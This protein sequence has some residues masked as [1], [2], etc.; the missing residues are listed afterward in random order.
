MPIS[1]RL[2]A[3]LFAAVRADET[4][5]ITQDLQKTSKT[6][7]DQKPLNSLLEAA[8]GMLKNGE[9]P[10]AIDFADRVL[11]DINATIIDAIVDESRTAQAALFNHWHRF[12]HLIRFELLGRADDVYNHKQVCKD[13]QDHHVLCREQQHAEC[14][15][16]AP[17][18]GDDHRKF[19][20]DPHD[21]S[22]KR[23]CERELYERH[24]EWVDKE[25]MLREAHEEL[26]GHFCPPDANGTLHTFRVEAAPMMTQYIERKEEAE[27][28]ELEYDNLRPSCI[29]V[30]DRLDHTTETC[31][32][33]QRDMEHCACALDRQIG[34]TITWFMD[35]Y[36]RLIDGW[37]RLVTTTKADE[38]IRH[39]EYVTLKNVECLLARIH[40]L[41]GRPCD[42]EGQVDEE[43]AHC[44]EYA[45]T[46]GVCTFMEISVA[47]T[48][49]VHT[50]PAFPNDPWGTCA[51][52]P[53]SDYWKYTTLMDSFNPVHPHD[54]A[55]A[56]YDY[57]LQH[58]E[59]QKDAHGELCLLYPEPPAPPPPCDW[60]PWVSECYCIPRPE[61]KPCDYEWMASHYAILPD[62][63]QAPFAASN[64][65]CNQYPECTT[66]EHHD[67]VYI[68]PV[69]DDV[70]ILPVD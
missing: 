21:L 49:S 44:H 40:E 38:A 22:G 7:R 34:D 54:P 19:P 69:H 23:P 20:R 15:G 65:G 30:H 17:Y 14:Y 1:L 13:A 48:W 33:A 28:A 16:Q 39:H 66:C 27:R 29:Q 12:N 58:F 10:E 25:T 35:Q 57:N 55:K 9:T 42:E 43:L 47:E 56:A 46:L 61:P 26:N 2:G 53:D 6:K 68:L 3:L 50:P 31:N 36:D 8:K 62:V 41:N 4:L 64:P 52:S 18:D 45:S 24:V 59:A 70:H 5:S 37:E 11:D 32:H 67:D 63:P 60:A 51:L